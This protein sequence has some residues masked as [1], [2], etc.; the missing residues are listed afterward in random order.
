MLFLSENTE[1]LM[2]VMMF[3][4]ADF[5]RRSE[6]DSSREVHWYKSFSLN[7]YPKILQ[8]QLPFNF[9]FSPNFEYHLD[10]DFK[11]CCFFVTNT[12]DLA[13][14]AKIPISKDLIDLSDVKGK[15]LLMQKV[16]ETCLRFKFTSEFNFRITTEEGIDCLVSFRKGERLSIDAFTKR[17]NWDPKSMRG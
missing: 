6:P 16:R 10:L 3:R 1:L 4:S 17:A 14:Y 9:L 15:E 13:P 2:L 12:Q 8:Q 5:Y 7:V 11:S